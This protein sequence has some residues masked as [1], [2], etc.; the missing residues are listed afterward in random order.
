MILTASAK[1]RAA[2]DA[3]RC[4]IGQHPADLQLDRR[5][6]I[7][8]A[9]K[10]D[11]LE[12]LD[13]AGA[14]QIGADIGDTS[15]AQCQET[16]IG[17]ECQSGL[18]LMVACLMV[19]EEALAAAGDPFDRTGDPP[20]RP[21]HQHVLGIDEILGPEATA[22]IGSDKPHCGRSHTQCASSVVPCRMDAL[23]RDMSDILAAKSIPMANDAARL[24]WIDDDAV[25][26]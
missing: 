15:D 24:H 1:P 16:P 18:R 6:A 7:D 20:R 26:V 14:H 2:S 12:S 3:D 8:G 4:G 5:N 25:I 17:V 13:P 9:R 11:V 19:A 10:M 22:D 21:R 23:A